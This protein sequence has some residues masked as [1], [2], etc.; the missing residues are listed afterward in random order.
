MAQEFEDKLKKAK[1]LL[2]MLNDP[3]ITLK[4]SMDVY[5]KGIKTLEDASKML[6]D[7]KLVFEE[8]E[9]EG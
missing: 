4:K 1:E 2:D 9:G 6:E 8:K 7:A 3:D 5:K